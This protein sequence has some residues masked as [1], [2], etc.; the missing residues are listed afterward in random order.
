MRQS[1]QE[2][3]SQ[4]KPVRP[5]RRTGRAAPDDRGRKSTFEDDDEDVTYDHRGGPAR[6]PGSRYR[7]FDEDE[8][9][10][11]NDYDDSRRNDGRNKGGG[12]DDE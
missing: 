1:Q 3:R 10:D 2:D 11:Y 6:G 8:V 5:P 12:W 9:E 7:D 4:G